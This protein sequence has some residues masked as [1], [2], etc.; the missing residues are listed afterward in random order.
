VLSSSAQIIKVA[1]ENGQVV[2]V[3][4]MAE[5][6]SR[7]ARRR[8][9]RKLAVENFTKAV[10]SAVSP[11]E[12]MTQV[13]VLESS[14]PPPLLYVCN[15]LSLPSLAN[16][17]ADVALRIFSIDRLIAYDEIG[18]LEN[19]AMSSPVKLRVCF[20]LRC[21]LNGLCSR[22]LGHGG[23]CSPTA[24]SFSRLPDHFQ[25]TPPNENPHSGVSGSTHHDSQ[26][27]P[28]NTSTVQTKVVSS[29]KAPEEFLPKLS[30]YA[31]KEGIDIETITPW[32][33]L[34]TE[35]TTSLWI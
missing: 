20:S 4:R 12:L 14:I 24:T 33:P 1:Q 9:R 16:T 29:Y 32:V 21:H 34:S 19:A 30:S 13:L 35:I 22:Y 28:M 25:I 31:N 17:S 15:N 10:Q 23:K 2:D 7:K 27:K 18:Y 8:L 6:A 26:R 3:N 5:K 11:A